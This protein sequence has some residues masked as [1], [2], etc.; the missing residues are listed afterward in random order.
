MT[1][2]LALVAVSLFVL[3]AAPLA[4][5]EWHRV[6][7]DRTPAIVGNGHLVTQQRGVGD[8]R[9]VSLRG[10]GDLV[11]QVG[12]RASLRVTADSNI[13]PILV[14]RQRGEELILETRQS[15]RSRTKPRYVLTVPSLHSVGI[16]GSGDAR[17]EGVASE[18]F[19]V[20]IGGSGRVVA[21]GRTGR[22]ALTIGG[23]GDID[24]RA[25]PA[26]SAN[27]T[28]GGSGTAQ[29]ATNGPLS[30]TI[31]GSGSIRYLGRPSSIA[32]SKVGSGTVVPIR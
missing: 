6:N 11:I 23:S 5:Q 8:F 32:V 18:R 27:V 25:L 12:P 10:A 21:R 14:Q 17:V 24:A 31:A 20:A 2:R 29:L 9:A 19:S 22:L 30:G 7:I 13:L 15:Y 3:A 28:I 16:A 1:S 26:S 4:A